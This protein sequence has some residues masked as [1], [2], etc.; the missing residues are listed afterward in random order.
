MVVHDVRNPA[1][2]IEYCLEEMGQLVGL[3]RQ[4]S[5]PSEAESV[6]EVCG[7]E[8]TLMSRIAENSRSS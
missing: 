8:E 3:K 5:E 6:F 1:T 7:R 2:T 4:E